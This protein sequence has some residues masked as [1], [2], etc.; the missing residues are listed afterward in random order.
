[1]LSESES[2][3]S[4]CLRNLRALNV[5]ITSR[6]NRSASA[7]FL[8]GVHRV[9]PTK[10]S[11]YCPPGHLPACVCVSVL[12]AAL[13]LLQLAVIG[14]APYRLVLALMLAGT[15][16]PSADVAMRSN[17]GG[18]R[19]N[20][21]IDSALTAAVLAAFGADVRS[22]LQDPAEN[23]CVRPASWKYSDGED[24]CKCVEVARVRVPVVLQ[25]VPHPTALPHQHLC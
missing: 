8:P 11:P 16:V 2:W 24:R 20:S 14:M 19:G 3:V 9:Q 7:S 4:R 1:M 12:S 5:I 23:N 17:C 25:A 21:D 22:R 13:Q 15:E 18:K 6:D 10:A